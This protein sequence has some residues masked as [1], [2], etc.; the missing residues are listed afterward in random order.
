MQ[1]NMEAKLQELY[2]EYQKLDNGTYYV[3]TQ[4]GNELYIP[5]NISQDQA[6]LAYAPG[7]GGSGNDAVHLRNMCQSTNP[8]ACVVAIAPSCSDNQD[9][10]NIGTNAI[11][12]LGGN[13][14]NAVYASFSAS[15][16][17][18]LE[19][20]ETY[21]Q[22]N[23]NVSLS[24]ISCDGCG[25]YGGMSDKYPTIKESETPFVILTGGRDYEYSYNK[26]LDAGYN[27]YYLEVNNSKK[28]GHTQLNKDMI[29]NLLLYALGE[30]DEIPENDLQYLLYKGDLN[31][32]IDFETIRCSGATSLAGYDKNKYKSVLKL[33]ALTF[34]GLENYK[35]SDVIGDGYVKANFDFLA[36]S[37]NEIRTT[38]SKANIATKTPTL[39][40]SGAAGLLSA[41]TA[42]I[43]KYTTMTVNLYSKLAQETEATQ[44]YGQSIINLDLQQKNNLTDINN[45]ITINDTNTTTPN[46]TTLNTT[47]PNGTTTN[48]GNTTTNTGT[49]NTTGTNTNTGTNTGNT[50]STGSGTS[51]GGSTSTGGTTSSGGGTST[52]GG[53]NNTTTTPFIPTNGGN[54]QTTPTV[55]NPIVNGNNM[56]WQYA[57]G[58]NLVLTV[59]NG[60]ITGMKFT[61]S[62]NTV[63]ELNKNINNILVGEIDKQYFD[64]MTIVDKSVEITI[65]PDYFKEL[66]LD[67]IKEI[68][69]KGGV[70]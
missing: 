25:T 7:S 15:G 32:P 66:S 29:D 36:T 59:D 39:P 35:D 65:K 38:I 53:N 60:T 3:K 54:T 18:G 5:A 12:A 57:D 9:I 58:H 56:T 69:F 46:G 8:P 51:T 22:N 49:T 48:T 63:E 30:Q 34:T 70:N 16:I 26:M 27:A 33:N 61:Y 52:G 64:T 42:C 19:R 62:Y 41:I 17:K 68:F 44:S 67:K 11:N 10:L 28:T 13:V 20:G 50:T 31:S 37:L 47:T 21:L 40:I 6:L 14:G 23:P 24:I 55:Q 4:N 1:T 45:G 43:D 2:G